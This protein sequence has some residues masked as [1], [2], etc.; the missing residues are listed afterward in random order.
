M[1]K[2][3]EGREGREKKSERRTAKSAPERNP[4]G[5]EHVLASGRLFN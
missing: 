5:I 2:G 3:W 1:G 4:E